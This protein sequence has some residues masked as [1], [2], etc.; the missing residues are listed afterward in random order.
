MTLATSII[1]WFQSLI[2][3]QWLALLVAVGLASWWIRLAWY[4][5]QSA[6]QRR[7]MFSSANAAQLELTLSLAE[8]FIDLGDT[9]QALYWL[10]EV[11]RSGSAKQGRAAQ[12]QWRK[13]LSGQQETSADG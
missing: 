6:K 7:L 4:R 9:A 8:R 1:A 11:Q 13:L 12:R 3:I 5:R 2:L 10:D